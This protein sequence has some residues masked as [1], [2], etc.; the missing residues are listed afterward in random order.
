[1]KTSRLLAGHTTI[2]YPTMKISTAFWFDFDKLQK[3]EVT[4]TEYDNGTIRRYTQK[5]DFNSY[6]D[7]MYEY[8]RVKKK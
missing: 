8:N 2:E 3:I 7:L 6:E 4:L 5:I 1:M